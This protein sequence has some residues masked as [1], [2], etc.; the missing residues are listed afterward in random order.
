MPHTS[1][2]GGDPVIHHVLRVA[3]LQY[4]GNYQ[5]FMY[6][7][8]QIGWQTDN[9]GSPY[10]DASSKRGLLDVKDQKSS[11]LR[12]IGLA[13]PWQT[14]GSPY[15]KRLGAHIVGLSPNRE[16]SSL[17]FPFLSLSSHSKKA[18]FKRAL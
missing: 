4:A 13:L 2:E 3:Y 12:S 8:F 16:S 15:S 14:P 17:V 7:T 11:P 1:W 5:E 6:V 9:R 18:T 10:K